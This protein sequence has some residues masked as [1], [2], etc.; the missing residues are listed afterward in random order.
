M[1]DLVD[2]HLDTV[3]RLYDELAAT[4]DA[5]QLGQG[6][7]VPSNR[8]GA[9]LWCVVGARETYASAMASGVWGPFSCSLTASEVEVP[10]ALQSKLET[11]ASMFRAAAE[12]APHDDLRLGFKLDLLEHESAHLGQLLRYLLGLGLDIPPGWKERFAL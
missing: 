12:A 9:Q 5:Q 10:A 3:F 7:P 4:L 2:E 6:L 1:T 11:S 8:I